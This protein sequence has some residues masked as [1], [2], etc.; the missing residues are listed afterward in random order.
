MTKSLL[1]LTFIFSLTLAYGQI[2]KATISQNQTTSEKKENFKIND[3]GELE[4]FASPTLLT[5]TLTFILESGISKIK[6]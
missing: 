3:K 4:I 1:I 2:K 6:N 5:L